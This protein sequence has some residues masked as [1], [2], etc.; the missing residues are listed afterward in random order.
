MDETS[1][2]AAE[3]SVMRD[4][5]ED[6]EGRF[7]E[8]DVPDG[9]AEDAEGAEGAE[10][11]GAY[12]ASGAYDDEEPEY[13]EE[14]SG[15]D[16]GDDGDGDGFG[17]P[18]LPDEAYETGAVTADEGY[19][20][21]EGEGSAGEGYEGEGHAAYDV[22]AVP[23]DQPLVRSRAADAEPDVYLDVP[24]LK[25]DEIDLDVENLRAHVSLQAEVLDLLKLNVGADVALGR[26]HLGISG[27]E[28]QVRLKVRLDNVASII[29]RVL[30]TL[31]RNP[32]ILEDLTRGV[33]AAVQD[34]GGGARQAV[35]ELGAGTGR[36]VGDIGRG[37]GSAV[38]D[39][40]RG[41]GEGVRDV[42]RGVGRG[43]EDVG[44]GAGGAV[45]GV[46]RGAGTA[47]EGVGRG[48]GAV[49]EGAGTAVGDV[50]REAGSA[51][52]EVGRGAGR[53][54]GDTAGGVGRTLEDTAGG[55]SGAVADAGDATTGTAGATG[56]GAG[57]A[58]DVPD[59]TD[60]P[61]APEA[62]TVAGEAV[63]APDTAA[64]RRAVRRTARPGR[65]RA[66]D[67]E[68]RDPAVRD[69]AARSRG[70]ARARRVRGEDGKL[71]SRPARRR[72]TGE[73]DEP[74]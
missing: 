10:D 45:E 59:V 35:G 50:G 31:D 13:Y 32:Q 49:A 2:E 42:G 22:P 72:A 6:D 23:E 8:Q 61:A 54:V 30:T 65:T 40:G 44:R 62:S 67:D 24:L 41:A 20:D 17:P 51:V 38:R 64:H 58:E 34:I 25:V 56:R 57:A 53:T 43:V 3:A 68:H 7:E 55:V 37:A 60:V 28:A 69:P 27:V 39:V 14:Q 4:G 29:N 52:G 74:P 5:A 70:G 36:A 16:S 66:P 33:G 47:V 12:A 46:G 48:A 26:V 21:Y 18:G 11:A 19:G 15:D 73:R 63:D 71:P 1:G 9:E